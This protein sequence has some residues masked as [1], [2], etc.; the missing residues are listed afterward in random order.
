MAF[1][2]AG[3]DHR[4]D[5]RPELDGKGITKVEQSA[6]AA[7]WA[8]AQEAVD[9]ELSLNQI[10]EG[11][12]RLGLHGRPHPDGKHPACLK[13]DTPAGMHP[14]PPAPQLWDRAWYQ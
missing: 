14:V 8:R 12:P 9:G 4:M 7:L 10:L 2:Y 6:R 13:A 11:A 3:I 5:P 1:R